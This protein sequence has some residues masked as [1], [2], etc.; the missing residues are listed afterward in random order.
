MAS[1]ISYYYY[2]YLTLKMISRVSSTVAILAAVVQSHQHM[3]TLESLMTEA[4]ADA[5]Y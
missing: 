1:V 2:Y 3:K 4:V 5:N